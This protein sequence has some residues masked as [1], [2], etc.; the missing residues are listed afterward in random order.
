MAHIHYRHCSE[1][2]WGTLQIAEDIKLA[3]KCPIE[4][5]VMRMTNDY[6]CH[7][8]GLTL[9]KTITGWVLHIKEQLHEHHDL[10]F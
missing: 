7:V 9:S 2:T 4:L 1:T 3:S 8:T 6:P 5:R 10:G